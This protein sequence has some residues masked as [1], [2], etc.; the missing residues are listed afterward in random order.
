MRSSPFKSLLRVICVAPFE[1]A[2]SV[3]SRSLHVCRRSVAGNAGPSRQVDASP[4][5][6]SRAS[7]AV[8]VLGGA[9]ATR[10][11]R[12]AD[13]PS[14]LGQNGSPTGR[15]R[16]AWGHGDEAA[17]SRRGPWSR[18]ARRQRAASSQAR[19]RC[20]ARLSLPDLLLRGPTKPAATSRCR[21]SGPRPD[22]SWHFDQFVR[23]CSRNSHRLVPMLMI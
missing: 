13:P 9:M 21:I 18:H 20:P 8:G 23:C 3:R 17:S 1:W 16:G 4:G 7:A 11:L 22:N 5:P 6:R 12:L 10:S 14:F 19:P 15:L 2:R